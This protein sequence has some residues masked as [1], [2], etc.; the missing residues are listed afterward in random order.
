M[1]MSSRWRF[2]VDCFTA[3]LYGACALLQGIA[4]GNF[5]VAGKQLGV[6]RCA[7]LA[8]LFGL[9]AAFY[10]LSAWRERRHG[11]KGA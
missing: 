4:A 3:A 2:R 6:D 7:G 8:V 11:E 1:G 10:A 5:Y 9:L